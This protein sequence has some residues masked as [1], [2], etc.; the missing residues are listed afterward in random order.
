MRLLGIFEA[1]KT[2]EIAAENDYMELS[3]I[4]QERVE[5]EGGSMRRSWKGSFS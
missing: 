3:G 1:I 5:A 4:H 2:R